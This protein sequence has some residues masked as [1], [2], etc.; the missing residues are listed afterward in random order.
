VGSYDDGFSEGDGSFSGSDNS[1][2]DHQKV[3]SDVSIVRESTHGG[4]FLIGEIKLG[5]TIVGI[6]L[7]NSVNLLGDFSSVMESVLTG[8]GD[9]EG[10]SGWMPSSNTSN[11][12]ETFVGLSG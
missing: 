12:S 7:S 5:G 1:S 9:G 11:L 4:N 10:N 6:L 3:F 8:S 2:L